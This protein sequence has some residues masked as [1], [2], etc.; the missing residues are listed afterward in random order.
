MQCF[1]QSLQPHRVEGFVKINVKVI[2][3]TLGQKHAGHYIVNVVAATVALQ[4]PVLTF[5]REAVFCGNRRELCALP[6]SGHFDD[7]LNQAY[8]PIG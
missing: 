6:R 3:P 8:G 1:P 2:Q 5:M 7:R 4:T